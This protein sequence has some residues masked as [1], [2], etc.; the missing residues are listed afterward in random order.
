MR[1]ILTLVILVTCISCIPLSAGKISGDYSQSVKP[2]RWLRNIAVPID[3]AHNEYNTVQI[4]FP[5]SYK[6]KKK[7]RTV[8]TLPLYNGTVKDYETNTYIEKSAE[9]YSIV[10]VCPDMGKT[11]Y[12]SRYYDETTIRWSSVPGGRYVTEILLPFLRKNF[13]L[14]QKQDY[15]G[16]FGISTGGRGA[17]LVTCLNPDEFGAVGGISGD[18]DPLS[19]PNDPLLKS[20]YGEYSKFK[21]RW[22]EDDNIMN[23]AENLRNIPVFLAHGKKDYYTP[24]EQSLVLAMRLKNLQKKKGG[25]DITY[26]EKK[27]YSRDWKYWVVAVPEAMEFFNEKL[28]GP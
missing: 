5:R 4:Y 11:I 24:R 3:K 16:I 7:Q 12:E 19:M 14:A 25:F 20:M 28:A 9:E 15:T 27:Y 8:I 6:H 17:L 13:N 22:K 23:L 10:V 18:Y 1:K 2:G 26:R 21:D